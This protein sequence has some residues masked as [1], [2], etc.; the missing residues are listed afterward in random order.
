MRERDRYGRQS[1]GERLGEAWTWFRG[2]R[3][4]QIVVG[5][6]VLGMLVLIVLTPGTVRFDELAEGDCL[7]VRTRSAVDLDTSTPIGDPSTISAILLAEG[8]ERTSCDGSHGHEVIAVVELPE[9]VGA[10]YPGSGP[11]SAEHTPSCVAAFEPYVGR[12]AEGSTYAAFVVVPDEARWTDGA[13][14]V[15]CLLQRVDGRY[16]DHAARDSGE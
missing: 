13:R 1:L 10:A 8:A 9:P 12:P 15:A 7:F 3:N 6:V 4:A 11:L 16:M 2:N 14:S 5:A